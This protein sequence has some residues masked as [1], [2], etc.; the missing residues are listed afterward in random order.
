MSVPS[1]ANA[2]RD[3][4]DAAANVCIGARG[5]TSLRAIRSDPAGKDFASAFGPP[6][7]SFG[8]TYTQHTERVPSAAALVARE[9]ERFPR[10]VGALPV[11]PNVTPAEIR[12][13]LAERFSF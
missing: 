1:T 6:M 9:V 3:T 11:A 10:E 4:A 7:R 8:M 12:A 2:P 13:D 5:A